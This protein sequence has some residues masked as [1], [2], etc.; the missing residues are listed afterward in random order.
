MVKPA[1]LQQKLMAVKAVSK[2]S[3]QYFLA[4]LAVSKF[5]GEHFIDRL[6]PSVNS[7]FLLFTDGFDYL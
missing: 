2:F 6:W 4:V 3:S 7:S 1:T 5:I